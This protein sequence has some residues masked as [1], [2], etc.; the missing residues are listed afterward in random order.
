MYGAVPGPATLPVYPALSA[1]QI[2]PRASNVVSAKKANES[3]SFLASSANYVVEGRRKN[4]INAGLF[5]KGARRTDNGRLVTILLVLNY[6]IGS[7]I[8]NTSQT[9]LRSGV[10]AATMLYVIAGE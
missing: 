2:P 8:L 6:M 3:V 4:N 5:G 7:G 1:S 10:A 9:F